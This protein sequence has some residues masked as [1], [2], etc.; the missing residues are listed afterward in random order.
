MC[1]GRRRTPEARALRRLGTGEGMF[2]LAPGTWMRGKST[3]R[4]RTDRSLLVLER[5]AVRADLHFRPLS[6][7]DDLGF[8]GDEL[9]LLGERLDTP[10]RTRTGASLERRPDLRGQRVERDLLLDLDDIAMG[11]HEDVTGASIDVQFDLVERLSIFHLPRE[12]FHR[13]VRSFARHRLVDRR[14]DSAFELPHRRLAYRRVVRVLITHERCF[15]ALQTM[16]GLMTP[17]C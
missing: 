5:L 8:V 6:G 16:G 15:L 17:V 10:D 1:V 14:R 7:G 11:L 3:G 13:G 9:P 2:I 4:P 12:A